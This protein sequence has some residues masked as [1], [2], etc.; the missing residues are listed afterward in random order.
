MAVGFE[1]NFASLQRL[2]EDFL[3]NEDWISGLNH[4]AERLKGDL[5]LCQENLREFAN[6]IEN[7]EESVTE[8]NLFLGQAETELSICQK[9][10][11]SFDDLEENFE[12]LQVGG[13]R[14]TLQ[15]SIKLFVFLLGF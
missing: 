8:W 13:H 12:R 7:F 14:F 4:S 6:E 1:E 10:S 11:K 2:E 5:R 3:T 15:N 9:S